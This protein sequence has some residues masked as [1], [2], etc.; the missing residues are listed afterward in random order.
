[1]LSRHPEHIEELLEREARR[2]SIRVAK[3]ATPP[4]LRASA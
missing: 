2:S 4:R 3:A 1:M